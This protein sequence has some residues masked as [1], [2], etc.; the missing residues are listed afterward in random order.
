LDKRFTVQQDAPQAARRLSFWTLRHRLLSDADC[1]HLLKD[2]EQ[3]CWKA[4]P[5]GNSLADLDKSDRART[6]VSDAVG[7]LVTRE[8]PMRARAGERAGPMLC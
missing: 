8:F 5:Y 3:V 6:H 2:F 4:D 1:K 7:Y